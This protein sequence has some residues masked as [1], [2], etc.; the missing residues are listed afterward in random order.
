MP[1]VHRLIC[2]NHGFSMAKRW[3]KSHGATTG[4]VPVYISNLRDLFH[5]DSEEKYEQ[6]LSDL[7]AT[8]S[9]PFLNYYM[10]EF[11]QKVRRALEFHVCIINLLCHR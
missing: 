6:L 10:T 5:Q 11:H 4:E 1:K 3:L 8:W 2:W 9:Q 7:K